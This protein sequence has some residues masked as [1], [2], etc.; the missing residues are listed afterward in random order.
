MGIDDETAPAGLHTLTALPPAPVGREASAYCAPG[1]TVFGTL[2]GAPAGSWAR[3][4]RGG[5]QAALVAAVW[6]AAFV[7]G[8]AVAVAT[9]PGPDAGTVAD[10]PITSPARAGA[11][12]GT[13]GVALP[14]PTVGA[15]VTTVTTSVAPTPSATDVTEPATSE[16]RGPS[17]RGK[18]N[19]QDP[20]GQA[21]KAH[22]RD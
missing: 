19:G 1:R 5:R 6:T 20:P 4:M 2:A 21:G 7:G 16:D 22:G 18:G 15:P 3:A 10:P 12:A 13:T 9:V 11:G 8:L 14:P 17:S